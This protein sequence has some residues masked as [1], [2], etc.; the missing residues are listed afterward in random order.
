MLNEVGFLGAKLVDT[1]LPLGTSFLG[2][3]GVLLVDVE[4][5]RRLVGKLL[6]INFTRLNISFVVNH[7]SQ[8]VYAPT[9]KHWEGALNVL[10]YLKGTIY[11]GLYFLASSLSQLQT[12]LIQIMLNV[13][14][15]TDQLL[16]STFFWVTTSFHG[17]A[18]NN[19]SSPYPQLKLSIKAWLHRSINLRGFLI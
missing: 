8:F 1:R 17:K 11:H 9:K 6:Y 5:Y 2:R 7:L 16:D 18:R 13:V 4:K 3:G 12:S 14:T 19:K 10:K 15:R